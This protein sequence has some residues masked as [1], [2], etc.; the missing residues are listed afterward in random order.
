MPKALEKGSSTEGLAL[1]FSEEIKYVRSKG[2]WA[3]GIKIERWIQPS[4]NPSLY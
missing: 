2:K 3:L 4:P 1:K